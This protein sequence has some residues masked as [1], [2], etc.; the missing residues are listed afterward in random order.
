M[1]YDKFRPLAEFLPTPN[2]QRTA[3]GAPG[4]AYWQQQADHEINVE[5]DEDTQSLKGSETITYHNNS[6]DTLTYLWLELDANLFAKHSASNLTEVLSGNQTDSI[7]LEKFHPKTLQA[8][9]LKEKF[10]GSSTID[11]VTDTEGKPLSFVIND[12][13]MRIDLPTPLVPGSTLRF[14]ISWHYRINDGTLLPVRTGY[15]YFKKDKNYIFEIANWYPR[16][17]SYT[18]VR[19][20][21][22]KAYLGVGEFSL[23]FGN[24]LVKIT[25]PD[26]H[27]VS[28]SGELQNPE[29]VLTA[30]QRQR[31]KEATTAKHPVFI[32]T[33]KEAQQNETHHSSGKKTW[34]FKADN[35]RAFAFASSRKFI[36]DAQGAPASVCAD[37]QK[38]TMAMSFYPKEAEPL[39]SKYSTAAV[40]HTLEVYTKHTFPF[41]YPTVNSINGPIFGMEFSMI[42][43]NGTRPEK[44]GTYS[45]EKKEELIAVVIHEVGHNFFPMI[46]NSDE[47]EWGWMDEGLNT[48]LE[49]LATD[50]W[51]KGFHNDRSVPRNLTKYMTGPDLVPIMTTADSLLKL[52]GSAYAKPAAGLNLLRDTVLGPDRFD[53]AFKTYANRWK[54]KRPEPADFFRTIGDASGRDL[55]WFWRGWF[56]SIDP[57][58]ISVDTVHQYILD[59]GTPSIDKLVAKKEKEDRVKTVA[60]I[61]DANIKTYAELHPELKDFYSSYD[62]FSVLPSEQEKFQ[63]LLKQL[64]E[65]E[66]DPNILTTKRNFY[67]IDFSNQGG[68]IM[69]IPLKLD[70]SDGTSEEFQIPAEIWRT[71]NQKVSKLLITNKELKSVQVD[72]HEELPEIHRDLN[73]WPRQLVKDHFQFQLE[74]KKKNP[75]QELEKK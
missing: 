23:E 74:E 14:N 30:T 40:L 63:K 41:P 48:F 1:A 29:Q 62:E 37:P 71:N 72:P 47:R 60:E 13:M 10:D 53:F 64:E 8:E 39:W 57:C 44:D 11:A 21:Q 22:N 26:D 27:I 45:R 61:R 16:M 67:V 56:Y 4:K 9:L 7:H 66:I 46:V 18:D 70:Y 20:W 73:F 38:R 2:D 58:S 24:Y 59:T 50:L 3:S 43:F 36:W 33:P 12:T 19:G 6:P 69:P 75:M 35:I 25:A 51:E 68:L 42:C 17:C 54:F 65:E 49:H 31:L 5:L 32:V 52:G 28:A 15:E 34:I 55:D